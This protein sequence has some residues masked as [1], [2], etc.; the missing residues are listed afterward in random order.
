[1][2]QGW[3]CRG[4]FLKLVVVRGLADHVDWYQSYQTASTQDGE[5]RKYSVY[6]T[7]DSRRPKRVPQDNIILSIEAY[8]QPL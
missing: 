3:S 4:P 6:F 5:V 1:M 7:K 2:R 8:T